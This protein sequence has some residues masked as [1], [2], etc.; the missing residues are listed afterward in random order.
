MGVDTMPSRDHTTLNKVIPINGS[1][2]VWL[3]VL[4]QVDLALR[5]PRN[6]GPAAR[7]AEVFADQLRDKLFTEG[8]LSREEYMASV[9][10]QLPYRRTPRPEPPGGHG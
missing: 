5:H 2:V 10:D 1:A 3:A 6:V 7:V 4:G 9:I 8:V